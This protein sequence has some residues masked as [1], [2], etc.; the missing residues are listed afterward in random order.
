MYNTYTYNAYKMEDGI[1]QDMFM[2]VE[3]RK[4][5]GELDDFTLG[6]LS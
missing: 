1:E 6:P 4:G 5:L 2:W 3:S